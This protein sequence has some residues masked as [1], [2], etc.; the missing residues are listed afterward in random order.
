[1]AEAIIGEAGTPIRPELRVALGGRIDSTELTPG[2]Q[3]YA[4]ETIL[5]VYVTPE[6]V[7]FLPLW[8]LGAKV[9]SGISRGRTHDG[10]RTIARDIVVTGGVYAVQRRSVYFHLAD[11]KGLPAPIKAEFWGHEKTVPDDGSVYTSEILVT[12]TKG[13]IFRWVVQWK[14][15]HCA[16]YKDSDHQV[17]Q[18]RAISWY[19]ISSSLRP[20]T[21]DELIAWMQK[22]RDPHQT[23]LT[24]L[25]WRIEL[26]MSKRQNNLQSRM[27]SFGRRRGDFYAAAGRVG[28]PTSNL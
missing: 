10:E 7:K 23:R 11:I 12:S 18:G 15:M 14:A 8:D 26:A 9:P 2:E 1:M 25:L 6:M 20:F 5:R 17:Y 4:L 13:K 3:A 24:Q 21:Q 19:G 22:E 16:E 28:G 27:R